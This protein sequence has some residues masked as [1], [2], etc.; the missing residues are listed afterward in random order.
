MVYTPFIWP[1]LIAALILISLAFYVRP[2]RD[3]PGVRPFQLMMGIAA[4]WTLI[5]TLNIST[6]YFPLKVVL[7]QVQL[8]PIMFLSPAALLLALE[9]TGRGQ[10]IT[11][12]NLA[13]LLVIPALSAV[14]LLTSP[15]HELFRYDFRLDLSGLVP[16]IFTAK[17]P[18]Y[19][20]YLAY[21]ML[22]ALISGGL[23]LLSFPVRTLHFRNALLIVAG[24]LVSLLADLFF[25]F[26]LSP[27]PGYNWLGVSFVFSGGFFFWALFGF[28]L[29]EVAPVARNTVVDSIR[30]LVVVIDGQGHIVDFNCAAQDRLGLSKQS[31]GLMPNSLP[32]A[33]AEVFHRFLDKT[34]Y[35]G[36]IELDSEAEKLFFDLTV[37]PILDRRSQ[38]MGRLFLFHDIT[39]RKR[40]EQSRN[41]SE[42]RYQQL[43][44][45]L[46]DGVVIHRNG[47]IVFANP[48]CVSL[49]G[50]KSEDELIGRHVMEF[51]HPD[52]RPTVI[53]R[54][55]QLTEDKESVP[56]IEEKFIRL[57]GQ[58]IDVEATSRPL[59]VGGEVLGLSIFHNINIRKRAE[60]KLRQ[61]SRAVEQSPT[62]IVITDPDGSI[63]YAN[64]KFSQ[65]TGYTLDEAAGQNPRILKGGNA[66]PDF[67]KNLW[68]T[69][70]AGNEWHGEFLN[71]KKDGDLYW[72]QASISPIIDPSG[73]IT[74]FVAVKEDITERKQAEAALQQYAAELQAQ[75]EELDAFSHTVAHDLKNPLTAMLGY[76]HL[77]T[78][79]YGNLTSE[80]TQTSLRRIILNGE[81]LNRII[82]ELML[83]SG[84]RKQ[85]IIPQPVYM[86]P[87][88]VEVQERLAAIIQQTGAQITILDAASW[89]QVLG[90]A[91]WIEEV[92][93]NYLSNALKY[94]GR[95]PQVELGATLQENGAVRFWV[96]DNGQGLSQEDQA[97]LFVPFTRLSQVRA[98]GHGLGLSIVR[99]ILE[100]LSG[101][102][103]VESSLGQGS[104]FFFSLPVV[105]A[106]DVGLSHRSSPLPAGET[107]DSSAPIMMSAPP[108]PPALFGLPVEW[109]KKMDWA[110]KTGDVRHI[111]E[112]CNVIHDDHPEI[113]QA[114]SRMADDFEYD[115]ILALLEQAL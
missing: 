4:L 14:L 39:K 107:G 109:L 44:E 49:I 68:D 77:L 1:Q 9:Y 22:L 112:L 19:W 113:A 95:P 93:A 46:P 29:F 76:A 103:G 27:V 34:E 24:M 50:A 87:I 7:H 99:R 26:E 8:L 35:K 90:Y 28:R 62:S 84:V 11:R 60:E 53:Q 16:L 6:V 52:S 20:L 59:E 75:N 2:Y 79:D 21:S 78:D 73:K 86:Q 69:I 36:E 55:Q 58:M 92:W 56:L 13:W 102:V 71:R 17:G 67:Y 106:V 83:L 80:Q 89:P 91:P 111:H 94:G 74:H 54:L 37:S 41:E 15:L 96:R 101:E 38:I 31:I 23:L 61:L 25:Q 43:V 51:V 42:T 115:A 108:S 57:D 47:Y 66:S 110:V 88:L 18:M 64:P 45:L 97:R 81:R 33:W 114:L 105:A 82:D 5:Y 48:A 10:W 70:T 85:E 32:P 12:R 3:Q 65:V 63:Q 30:D 98:S 100:K 40:A 104:T 72:E